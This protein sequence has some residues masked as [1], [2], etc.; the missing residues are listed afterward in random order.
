MN[1]YKMFEL[2]FA[3]VPPFQD[4]DMPVDRLNKADTFFDIEDRRRPQQTIVLPFFAS[5]PPLSGV[6]PAMVYRYVILGAI[7]LLLV[8]QL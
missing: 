8:Y 7:L 6:G 4:A 5:F 2:V 1:V 3:N